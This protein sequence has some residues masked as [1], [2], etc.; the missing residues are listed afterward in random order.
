MLSPGGERWPQGIGIVRQRWPRLSL[1][2]WGWEWEG[3]ENKS[4]RGQR[5]SHHFTRSGRCQ[6]PLRPPSDPFPGGAE[7]AQDWPCPARLG[8][9]IFPFLLHPGS[10]SLHPHPCCDQAQCPHLS[11]PTPC[12]ARF[13]HS[14]SHI[15]IP[16]CPYPLPLIP[17][18]AASSRAT[19]GCLSGG[20]S[21]RGHSPASQPCCLFTF[22]LCLGYFPSG[23][24]Q[25]HGPATAVNVNVYG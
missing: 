2:G 9:H 16:T 21:Q 5:R 22:T 3:R 4:V 1:P 15:P 20:N 17:K 24:W 18:L 8:V 12:P 13:Q 25:L 11:V 6:S 23:S 19:L 10:P 7:M 14:Y